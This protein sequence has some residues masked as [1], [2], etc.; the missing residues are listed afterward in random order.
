MRFHDEKKKL[1]WSQL[2]F[3]SSLTS[4]LHFF[5]SIIEFLA[6]YNNFFRNFPRSTSHLPWGGVLQTPGLE[7]I[8]FF[9]TE[10]PTGVNFGDVFLKR[11][12]RR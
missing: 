5:F 7:N 4:Y 2:H 9:T 8:Q 10:M 6:I 11:Y 1:S 3:V 12:L